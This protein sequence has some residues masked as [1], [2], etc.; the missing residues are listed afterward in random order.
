MWLWIS[1]SV[2]PRWQFSMPSRRAI[3]VLAILTMG[4]VVLLF[5]C[6][7]QA[8][9]RARLYRASSVEDV[10]LATTGP[11]TR[12]KWFNVCADRA[13]ATSIPSWC[14]YCGLYPWIRPFL[15]I[16]AIDVNEPGV[17]D[18]GRVAADPGLQRLSLGNQ[19]TNKLAM[20]PAISESQQPLLIT[21]RIDNYLKS[22]TRL[23]ALEELSFCNVSLEGHGLEHVAK[24]P[25]LRKLRLTIHR[26]AEPP[27]LKILY[28][29]LERMTH[30]EWLDLDSALLHADYVRQL[31]S[32]PDLKTLSIEI[33]GGC[34][35]LRVPL[36]F[37]SL[38]QLRTI[39]RVLLRF[40]L[41]DEVKF[42]PCS[43]HVPTAILQ[44]VASM[45]ELESLAIEYAS[46][47]PE[48][49]K[50]LDQAKAL[51]TLQLLAQQLT[52][53][54]I[55]QISQLPHITTLGYAQ[56]PDI[57]ALD[58]LKHTQFI[59]HGFISNSPSQTERL[60]P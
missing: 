60:T 28:S 5:P 21:E 16:Q 15:R 12:T 2:R 20:T 43:E 55:H 34:G 41:W 4:L 50:T 40:L 31:N 22:L 26:D 9:T 45:P 6:L 29:H 58:E 44:A 54:D 39:R 17:D 51:H 37:E 48:G 8:V 10:T 32:L 24:L 47:G 42:Q 52:R 14:V 30:L 35:Q 18:F 7:S 11:G 13:A 25:S 19:R 3:C 33:K 49:L 59:S 36:H 46:V 27:D 56:H 53:A 1:E 23:S 57:A 38:S